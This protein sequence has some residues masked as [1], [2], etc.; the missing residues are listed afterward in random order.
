[1]QAQAAQHGVDQLGR[2]EL[3]EEKIAF[4][5][6]GGSVEILAYGLAHGLHG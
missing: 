5:Q 1:M 3:Q 6:A 2:A 4:L